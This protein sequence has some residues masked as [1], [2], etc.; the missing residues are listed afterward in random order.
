[1][2]LGF[3]SGGGQKT[4]RFCRAEKHTVTTLRVPYLLQPSYAVCLGCRS[5]YESG[6][7]Q[8]EPFRPSVEFSGHY[9]WPEVTS[10]DVEACEGE[11]RA[12]FEAYRQARARLVR[13][14]VEEEPIRAKLAAA[15]ANRPLQQLWLRDGELATLAFGVDRELERLLNAAWE[16][17]DEYLPSYTFST[18]LHARA[19][20][21]L[22]TLTLEMGDRAPRCYG[23]RKKGPAVWLKELSD[24]ARQEPA[25]RDPRVPLVRALLY[26]E[27]DNVGGVDRELRE[28]RRWLD[29]QET[30]ES[31][32]DAAFAIHYDLQVRASD[33][34]RW[35]DAREHLKA[36]SGLR[37]DAAQVFL[38]LAHAYLA[39]A[40]P[41][42]ARE[43]LAAKL[44]AGQVKDATVAD[45]IARLLGELRP[46]IEARRSAYPD[47]P[48]RV[49]YGACLHGLGETDVAWRALDGAALLE[50]LEWDDADPDLA[51]RL[52]LVGLIAHA[53]GDAE[54]ALRLLEGARGVS[55]AGSARTRI[56]HDLLCVVLH[57]LRE[58]LEVLEH[59]T[60]GLD[61]PRAEIASGLDAIHS[62]V[63]RQAPVILAATSDYERAVFTGFLGRELGAWFRPLVT[64][65]SVSDRDDLRVGDDRLRID[66][67]YMALSKRRLPDAVRQ[68]LSARG[69]MGHGAPIHLLL[70]YLELVRRGGALVHAV[71]SREW[72]TL[73]ARRPPLEVGLLIVPEEAL[74]D[75]DVEALAEI[76]VDPARGQTVGRRSLRSMRDRCQLILPRSGRATELVRDPA[77][78]AFVAAMFAACPAFPYVLDMS[79]E[80]DQFLLF[81]GCL[82]SPDAFLDEAPWLNLLDASVIDPVERALGAIRQLASDVGGDPDAACASI[83]SHYPREW[84][85][86]AR[87]S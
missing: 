14:S 60:R 9:L 78:R 54:S 34:R 40:Q 84:R 48:L 11:L 25:L 46:Q 61:A 42:V 86:R 22:A 4:C 43:V 28:A 57:E 59:E 72:A 77:V 65:P 83:L 82:A 70:T 68:D 73:P 85:P 80:R 17:L 74:S 71:A 1:M 39:C 56:E 29:A 21:V 63:R 31:W 51:E 37:P 45:M 7:W 76:F 81:F 33:E 36:C 5:D 53:R 8:L 18:G 58:G 79:P 35:V 44:G 27:E 30:P 69:V 6:G 38:R 10:A 66:L 55:V 23:P 75:C 24:Q 47:E 32:S 67:T 2:S 13:L 49:L 62:L 16:A 52:H 87:P 12:G 50:D 26:R 20:V 64:P 41:R 19:A 3:D 15:P